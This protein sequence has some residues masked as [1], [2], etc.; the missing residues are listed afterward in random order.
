MNELFDTEK[1]MD[2]INAFIME[3]MIL[4]GFYM[5]EVLIIFG[6]FIFIIIF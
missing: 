4:F 6:F 1:F 5:N 2:I 3:K